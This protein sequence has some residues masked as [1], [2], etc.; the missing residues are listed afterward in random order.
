MAKYITLLLAV[1]CSF[2][3]FRAH[4]YEA[5]DSLSGKYLFLNLP[6]DALQLIPE[7][8]AWTWWTIMR[9]GRSTARSMR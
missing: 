4:S 7:S 3:G 9:P 6:G 2:A 8:R 1:L 5:A